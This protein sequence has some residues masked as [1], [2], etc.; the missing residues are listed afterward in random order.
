ML[1]VVER[2]LDGAVLLVEGLGT[3]SSP[4]AEDRVVHHALGIVSFDAASGRYT[5]RSYL[6]TGQ[7]GDFTLTPIEGG[8]QWTR[9]VPGGRVRNTARYTSDEWHEIGEFSRDGE[10]WTQIMELR[11]KRER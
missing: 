11:L 7:W 4:G 2:K 1:E 9:E 5:L 10:T 8:V 3:V 6:A